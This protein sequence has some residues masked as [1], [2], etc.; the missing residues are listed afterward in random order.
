[1]AFVRICSWNVNS[2]RARLPLVERLVAERAP[3]ILCL[4]E[5]KVETDAFPRAAFRAMGYEHEA[6]FGQ[7]GHHGVAILS[8][9]A[10]NQSESI[11]WCSLGD[12]RHISA[13]LPGGIRLHDFYVPA[14]GDVPDPDLNPRFAHKLAFLD[15]MIEWAQR[16]AEPT[17][18]LGDFNVA[19]LACDVWNHKALLSVVSHTPVETERLERLRAAHDWYDAV[20]AV[21]TAPQPI[22]TWWSYRARDWRASNRG[23][24]LDH[25]WLSPD[26]APAL[27][28]VE[29]VE[30]ARGWERPSDHVP[31]LVDL[32]LGF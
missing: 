14:G 15:E 32:D 30:E 18:A 29:I 17:I 28:G 2:V 27:V 7:R 26:L 13:E 11:D 12:A 10:L 31:V 24:R 23:R 3:D 19:P 8:R 4:Q 21:F 5:I 1:M 9:L 25:V 20:R 22:F 16:L 6:I